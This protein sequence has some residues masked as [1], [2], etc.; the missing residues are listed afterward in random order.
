MK[1]LRAKTK[2]EIAAEMRRLYM[3]LEK[4]FEGALKDGSAFDK[5]CEEIQAFFSAL[6]V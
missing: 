4:G 5:Q 1:K 2:L 6:A 3:S